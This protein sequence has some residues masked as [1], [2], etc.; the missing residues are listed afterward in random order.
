MHK[1]TA[2]ERSFVL[3]SLTGILYDSSL[4]SIAINLSVGALIL[5]AFKERQGFNLDLWY[6]LLIVAMFYR[7]VIYFHY[8]NHQNSIRTLTANRLYLSGI[9]LTVITWSILLYLIRGENNAVLIL[10]IAFVF[11]GISSGAI[12]TLSADRTTTFVYLSGMMLPMILL[13]INKPEPLYQVMGAMTLF[14]LLFLLSSSRRIHKTLINT[15]ELKQKHEE[16]L[17][18]LESSSR[19][20]RL[21]FD[22][23]PVGI[24]FYSSHLRII[25][26]NLVLLNMLNVDKEKLKTLYLDTIIDQRILPALKRPLEEDKSGFY[27]GD[28]HTY[29]TNLD[30]N[31]RLHTKAVIN[32]SGERVGALGIVE[33]IAQEVAAQNTIKEFARF[34]T[35]NP[36]PVLQFSCIDHT[37]TVENSAAKQLR[38]ALQHET[39]RA[40][41]AF[42]EHFCDQNR[43]SAD[44]HSGNRIF[45]FDAVRLD[46]TRL[47]LYGRDVTTEREAQDRADFLAYY[48]DLTQLPRRALFFEHLKQAMHRSRR[49]ERHQALLFLDLDD[50]KQIN[51]TLGHD[52][53]DALLVQLAARLQNAARHSDVVARLGGDEFVILIT[54]LDAQRTDAEFNARQKA[55]SI[56]KSIGEPF[57]IAEQRLYF[58]VSIGI[59]LFKGECAPYDLLKEADLAMYE[60][61][62]YGKNHIRVFDANLQERTTLR[63]R[64]LQDL[65]PAI[66]HQEFELYFQPQFELASGR[67]IGAEALLRW[68]HPE[69]GIVP[70][71][72]FIPV[73]EESGLIAEIGQWV[74]VEASRAVKSM[75]FLERIAINVSMRELLR[76]DYLPSLRR[77]ALEGHIDPHRL[78]LELT[79][80]LF[81]GDFEAS[82]A[83]ISALTELGFHISID[84]F[85]TGYSSLS[86]L[87]NMAL[88]ALKI[89]RSFVKDIGIDRDDEVLAQTIVN[90]ANLYGMQTTAEGIE[91]EEQFAFIK[92]LGC[93]RAQGYYLAEPMTMNDFKRWYREVGSVDGR[94]S[95]Q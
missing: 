94:T 65:Y 27:E 79:E 33:D 11:S 52:T 58:S 25:D 43:D 7:G 13:L 54:D 85:G 83:M 92:A 55:D 90:I 51:D 71:E 16:T 10:F 34:Y 81:V 67:C 9:M 64:L 61:K 53:G 36:N 30:L 5:V 70:P 87:K 69:Q 15:L 88:D 93:T 45:Q 21:I 14:F 75:P 1:Q 80:S 19:R 29:L 17:K 77:L 62:A 26:A 48:D 78:E 18:M 23:V 63:S 42:L 12:T 31:I 39:P 57:Q 91:N 35:E 22:Q 4:F 56:R 37:V 72:L 86:Y 2:A 8:R 66:Q 59:T 47:N 41:S 84:D 32:A 40:W 28:Y 76:S 46:T 49:N 38:S 44:L 74:I 60:A 3:R 6:L 24:F 89:D 95:L 82:N 50:F 73:A 68:H 20:L